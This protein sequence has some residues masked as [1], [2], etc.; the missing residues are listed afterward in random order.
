M[1]LVYEIGGQQIEVD[2]ELSEAEIDEIASS[3]SGGAAGA[4]QADMVSRIPGPDPSQQYATAPRENRGQNPTAL[5]YGIQ[6]AMAVPVLA[7]VARGAQLGAQGLR[8][9]K[10]FV[11]DFARSVIPRSGGQLALEGSM[12][13]AAGV[14]G[15]KAA[16]QMEGDLAK[17]TVGTLAGMAAGA[18]FLAAKNS[19]DLWATRGLGSEFRNA[20]VEGAQTV[21]RAQATAQAATAL[22]AN[23]ELG[24]TVL[25]AQ[26]IE[27]QTGISL[28]MLAASN[29]DTTISS[30]LQSQTTRGDNAPFAAALSQQYKTAERQLQQAKRGKAPSMQEVD[31]YVKRKALETQRIN[32]EAVESARVLST[33]RQK[34]ID[35]IDKRIEEITSGIVAP[36]RTETGAALKNLI[37][38]KETTIRNELSPQYTKILEASKQQGINLPGESARELR[39]YV[40]D[41][42]NTDVFQKFPRLFG[43]IK[44]EFSTP[45]TTS[46]RVAEKYRV[47]VQSQQPKDVS[48]STLDSLKRE[49]N[50]AIRDTDNKDDLRRL[51]A[52]KEQV[53][54]AIDTVDP[55]FSVPYRAL[56][57]EFATRLGMP[58][59]EQGVVNVDRAQFVERT[60][61]MLTS[62]PSALRQVKAIVGDSPEGIKIIEDAFLFKIA[63][64][65]S[66]INTNTGQLNTA[67]LNRYLNN[68]DTKAMLDEVPG[69]QQRLQRMSSDVSTLRAHKDAINTASQ[70]AKIELAEN[71]YTKAYS[72]SGG[73]R[74][75]VRNAKNN[76]QQFDD[77]LR[78]VE[79]DKIAQAG[80]KAALMEDAFTTPGGGLQMF[81]DNRQAF[82]KLFGKTETNNMEYIFE[83]SQRLTDNPFQF[84]VNPASITKTK[85][86]KV[87][88]SKPETSVGELRNQVMTEARSAINHIS[89]FLQGKASQAEAAE[90]QRFL[91]DP[92]A[93]AE[94]ASAMQQIQTKGLGGKTVDILKKVAGN[95]LT[96]GP[97]TGIAGGAAG[98]QTSAPEQF[99]PVDETLLEGFGQQ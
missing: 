68:P 91:S 1:S 90:M 60:V 36:G 74:G 22:R 48:L 79:N 25:R 98:S 40:T 37:K 92:K 57:K 80:V 93:L 46:G 23:P 56:D 55:A 30:F 9:A 52:L 41:Q 70:N 85:F 75:V 11:D 64:D 19:F 24:P 21:G 69:L 62:T 96:Y 12:G 86:E 2:K 34:G 72:T 29:G 3:L 81:K 53:D 18:P 28:P 67:Q 58:F 5:D 47:A 82:E 84:K 66:I 88:G 89:R 14:V 15:G 59:R 13:A 42:L 16:E 49:T 17:M 94:V 8:G 63:N 20:G 43:M 4:G 31:G 77:L 6:G 71:L 61:P 7:G 51:Y 38:A 44:N 45:A 87:T 35:N 65:K 73:M 39:N 83:A 95:Y 50:R 99:M 32:Q 78:S 26:E 27:R 97:A 10:P 33:H 76:P 54:A